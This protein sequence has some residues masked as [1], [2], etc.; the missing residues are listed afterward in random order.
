ML[1]IASQSLA[2]RNERD[3]YAALQHYTKAISHLKEE[4]DSASDG[5]FLTHF[6]M[7]V[8]EVS[9]RLILPGNWS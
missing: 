5:V 2:Q 9:V 8:Y 7:L 6:L 1:A 3:S 4:E